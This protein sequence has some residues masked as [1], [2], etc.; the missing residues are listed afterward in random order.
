MADTVSL[1]TLLL[2]ATKAEIYKK[3]L[4]IGV[5]TGLLTESWE[6]GDPTRSLWDATSELAEVW[7]ANRGEIVAG[8]LLGLASGKWLTLLLAQNYNV[9]RR[10]ATFATCTVEV[11]NATSENLGTIDID[12]LTFENSSTGAT[13]RNTESKVL[14]PS[15]TVTFEVEAE[16][17]GTDS[18]AGIGDID[19]LVPSIP[20]VTATNTTA[21]V[22]LDEESDDAATDRGKAKL[23]SFSPAGPKGAYDY[24]I[25]TPELQ[26]DGVSNVTRTRIVDESDIG[27]VAVFVAG[28]SGAVLAGDVTKAEEAAETYANP[29]KTDLFVLNTT[30]KTIAVTY[31]LWVYDTINLTTAEIE[32]LVEAKLVEEFPKRP[33]GGDVIP[34]ATSGKI[35]RDWIEAQ[36]LAAVY[37]HGFRCTVSTPAADVDLQLDFQPQGVSIAEVA[38]LG[39]ITPAVTIVEKQGAT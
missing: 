30:N 28:A 7:E 38:V 16:V 9:T 20:G 31:A 11:T 33:I 2:K 10:V 27:Q 12:D 6:E 37:P 23:E 14:G 32:D 21:A 8:G 5:V 39:T 13:Y 18:N 35:Y 24:A 1:A 17:A 36:I 19:T 34:P 22:A 29:H 26:T 25:K 4:D 3:L 15:S